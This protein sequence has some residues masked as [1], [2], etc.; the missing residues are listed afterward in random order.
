MSAF[1]GYIGP[2]PWPPLLS[3]AFVLR[4]QR[5][6][7]TLNKSKIQVLMITMPEPIYDDTSTKPQSKRRRL[8]TEDDQTPGSKDQTTTEAWS[9]LPEL[10]CPYG[11]R[12]A[13]RFSEG[14][15]QRIYLSLEGVKYESS[16]S[17]CLDT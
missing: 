16:S 5:P 1:L 4:R 14:D 15:C 10:R 3:F 13:R 11:A 17:S 8:T 7:T 12:N 2:S 9:N 6:H